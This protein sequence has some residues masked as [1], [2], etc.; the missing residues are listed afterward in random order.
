MEHFGEVAHHIGNQLGVADNFEQILVSH[1]V[2]SRE[3]LPLLVQVLTECLLNDLQRV[4]EV[5]QGFLEIWDFHHFKHKRLLGDHLHELGEVSVDIF[6][7]L[8]LSR[9]H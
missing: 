7:L 5:L 6:E 8:E 9:E 2:E 3:V 1:E 4:G